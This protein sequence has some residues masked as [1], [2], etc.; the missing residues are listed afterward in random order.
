MLNELT[1]ALYNEYGFKN[2]RF[3]GQAGGM[4]SSNYF[5]EADSKQLLLKIYKS[6]DIR[7]IEIIEKITEFLSLNNI[8]VV[9]PLATKNERLHSKINDKYIAIYPKIEGCILQGETLDEEALSSFASLISDIHGLAPYCKIPL[10]NTEDTIKSFDEIYTEAQRVKVLIKEKPMGEEVD[11]IACNFINLKLSILKNEFREFEY[12]LLC[13]DLIHGDCHAGNFLFDKHQRIA[14][15][16]D[17]ETVHFGHAIEDVIQYIFVACYDKDD[18]PNNLLR[19]K[20]FLKF[21]QA[22]RAL[23]AEE[24]EFGLKYYLYK[25]VR[26]FFLE[27]KLYLEKDPSILKSIEWE[28]EKIKYMSKNYKNIF[29]NLCA[30]L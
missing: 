2:I 14:A 26:S 27:N 3:I 11:R 8:P 6:K 16:L 9:K 25:M 20:L 12:V 15:A 22:K 4:S 17:F 29:R 24:I 5:I 30:T 19:A 18:E 13:D 1:K 7:A 28:T 23:I 21:Y 10:Y